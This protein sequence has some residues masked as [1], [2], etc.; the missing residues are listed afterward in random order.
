MIGNTDTRY[1]WNLTKNIYRF[2]PTIAMGPED[3]KRFHG[4][5]ERISVNNYE[6]VV[7]FFYHVMQNA[8]EMAVGLP[9]GHSQELW[10]TGITIMNL[11]IFRV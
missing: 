9:H 5:N 1:Y 2:T 11:D 7:N 6:K 10:I 8:D 4:V 3:L